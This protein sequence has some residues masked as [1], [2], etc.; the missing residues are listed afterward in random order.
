MT[1]GFDMLRRKLHSPPGMIL[2]SFAGWCNSWCSL[3]MSIASSIVPLGMLKILLDHHPAGT[4]ACLFLSF[5]VLMLN[6]AMVLAKVE[7]MDLS[8]IPACN[9]YSFMVMILL[10]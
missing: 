7:R 5:V 10:S 3:L 6:V 8:W 2:M 1:F 4:K 9:Y